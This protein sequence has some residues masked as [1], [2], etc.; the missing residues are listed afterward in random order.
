MFPN[1]QIPADPPLPPPPGQHTC[2]HQSDS[3]PACP[4][5][6]SDEL[7]SSRTLLGLI[8]TVLGL[9]GCAAGA[10]AA[11][12]PPP[13]LPAP[14][15]CTRRRKSSSLRIGNAAHSRWRA[16][17][18]NAAHSSRRACAL[19]ALHTQD[20]VQCIATLHTQVVEPAHWQR[21]TLKTACNALQGC[22]LKSSSLR[23]ATR[24]TQ[25]G[26]ARC[27]VAH[28]RILRTYGEVARSCGVAQC[29]VARS[30]GVAQC[31]VARSCGVA[32]CKVARV[33]MYVDRYHP[34]LLHTRVCDASARVLCLVWCCTLT[35][36]RIRASV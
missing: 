28:A 19:A 26:G 17:Y 1:S 9:P 18:C 7:A 30:C 16:M 32:Q 11:L 31:K 13:L 14:S 5:S 24:H 27:A 36:L 4:S 33:H 34:S 15:G 23:M 3:L 10:A 2:P 35:T 21:G 8:D 25:D 20:G 29:K 6:S 12:P 22:T